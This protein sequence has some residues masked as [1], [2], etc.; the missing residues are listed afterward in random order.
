MNIVVS[1]IDHA[2]KT[3][4]KY[5]DI[6]AKLEELAK[7]LCEVGRPVL[8]NIFHDH[9]TIYYEKTERG[10]KLVV[11]GED[12]LFIEFGAGNAA[13]SNRGLYDDVPSNVEP[14]SWSRDHAKQYSTYGFW[15]F[16]GKRYTEIKP[17]SGTYHAYQ[18]MVE[19]LPQIASEVFR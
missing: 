10:Y 7:R 4:G 6:E 1:G 8:I 16:G 12:V 19:A 13:G 3:V 2:I 9:A 14:G 18:A 5:I 17:H 15:Y 11:E